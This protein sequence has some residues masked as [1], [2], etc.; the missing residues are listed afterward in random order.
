MP[1]SGHSSSSHSSHSSSGGFSRGFS[2][3]SFGFGGSSSR[4][5]GHSSSSHSSFSGASPALRRNSTGYRSRPSYYGKKDSELRFPTPPR[6]SYTYSNRVFYGNRH[7]YRYYPTSFILNGINYSA[8]YYDEEGTHYSNLEMQDEKGNTVKYLTCEYCGC[9]AEYKPEDGAIPNCAH[10]GAPLKIENIE[11]D[12]A[13][14]NLSSSDSRTDG[15]TNSKGNKIV[16]WIIILFVVYFILKIAFAVLLSTDDDYSGSTGGDASYYTSYSTAAD[17]QYTGE[18]LYL[19]RSG[20]AF[21]FSDI[22][23][24]D[25]ELVWDSSADSYYDESGN[26]WLWY[27]RD[28]SPSIWQYWFEGVSSAYGSSGWMEYENGNWYIEVSSGHWEQYNGNVSQLWHIK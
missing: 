26:C 2:S 20:T 22:N 23:D 4:P 28:V 17:Q 18:I 6:E 7:Q 27:N 21:V 16:R 19:K 12:S 5:S 11:K 10:C 15:G 24:Y 14:Q 1:P 3:S 13:Y 8:G 9:Q 25:K